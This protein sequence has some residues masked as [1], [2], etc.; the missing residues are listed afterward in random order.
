MNCAIDCPFFIIFKIYLSRS[1][2]LIDVK[3]EKLTKEAKLK[4]I[5]SESSL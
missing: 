4:R 1:K 3:E 2:A 5:I